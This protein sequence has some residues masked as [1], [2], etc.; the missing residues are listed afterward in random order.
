MFLCK[1]LKASYMVIERRSL[2]NNKNRKRE[3]SMEIKLFYSRTRLLAELSSSSSSGCVY[4]FG[5]CESGG[6]PTK[7]GEMKKTSAEERN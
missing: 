1:L 7:K 4:T 3:Y 2:N 5:T 6:P